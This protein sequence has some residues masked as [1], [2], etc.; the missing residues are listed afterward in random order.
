VVRDTAVIKPLFLTN[1]SGGTA[2]MS[3]QPQSNVTIYQLL[4]EAS[5]LS[6]FDLD[7]FIS[8]VRALRAKRRTLNLAEREAE[9]LQLVYQGIPPDIHQRLEQLTAKR[10]AETIQPGDS[11]YDELIK[12]TVAVEK[13]DAQR[14]GYLVELANLRGVSLD[15]LLDDL[16]IENFTD[17]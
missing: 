15:A 5:E 14:L 1:L 13:L 3:I 2:K 8:Q 7:A 10:R 4:R 11:E 9:L 17:G 16:G 6:D 12:L